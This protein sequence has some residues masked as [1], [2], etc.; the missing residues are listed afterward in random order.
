[1]ST[2]VVAVRTDLPAGH[3]FSATDLHLVSVP[4]AL[5]GQAY[6]F[7]V[8]DVVGHVAQGPLSAGEFVTSTRLVSASDGPAANQR[9]VS[10][11]VADLGTLGLLHPGSVVDVLVAGDGFAAPETVAR[12]VQVVDIPRDQ[13]GE[14]A[15]TV[16]ITA[17]PEVA[18]T[19]A[20][21]ALNQPLAIAIVR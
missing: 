15:G 8:D 18:T 21:L 20:G 4:S 2:A 10:V 3:V 14:P 1:M 12:A 6:F 7:A 16:A 17:A 13:R 9:V 11:P 19:L 5:A